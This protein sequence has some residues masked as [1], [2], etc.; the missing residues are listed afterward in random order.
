M[1]FTMQ[2][3]SILCVDDEEMVLSALKRTLR[4]ENYKVYTANS[5]EKGL[6]ILRDVE[7]DLILIDYRMPGMNGLQ[8]LKEAKKIQPDTVR[9]LITGYTAVGTITEMVNKG[10]IHQIIVKPWDS[11][12]LKQIIRN[13]L[14]EHVL[15]SKNRKMVQEND[16]KLEEL[17][18]LNNELVD[19]IK[20]YTRD[21][22]IKM[23][24]LTIYRDTLL[25]LPVGVV[26]IDESNTIVL[27]N[28][29]AK[30]ILEPICFNLLGNDIEK[31]FPK[32][33]KQM[34]QK[35]LKNGKVRETQMVKIGNKMFHIKATRLHPES[36][37]RGT[38][39]TFYEAN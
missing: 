1:E 5:G 32:E 31:I 30:E 33:V 21:S 38:T 17:R 16:V 39:L 29:K 15:M 36:N 22:M 26:G 12:E 19:R 13:S 18:R 4:R 24:A 25:Y 9:I 14:E 27:V 2:K 7:I 37:A 6:E 11:E 34:V 23:Q 10:G 8:F 20:G 35:T 28:Q 3:F